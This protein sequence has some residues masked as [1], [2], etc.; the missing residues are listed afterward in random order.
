MQRL[1]EY[2]QQ[3]MT[4]LSQWSVASCSGHECN[5]VCRIL[6]LVSLQ[7]KY[8]TGADYII[9]RTLNWQCAGKNSTSLMIC[10]PLLVHLTTADILIWH[11][12]RSKTLDRNHFEGHLR[13]LKKS[14]FFKASNQQVYSTP[15]VCS[16]ATGEAKGYSTKGTTKKANR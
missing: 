1:S 6:R 8:R 10:V 15:N 3:Y 11:K 13:M 9:Y 12:A 16:Q 5:F 2:Q 7:I 4:V 14:L